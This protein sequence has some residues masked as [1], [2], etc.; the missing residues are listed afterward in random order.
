MTATP[1][2]FVYLA[3]LDEGAVASRVKIGYSANP[4]R[5][6]GELRTTAPLTT[7]HCTWSAHPAWEHA[8]RAAITAEGCVHVGGEVFDCLDIAG[9][10]RRG[11]AFFALMPGRPL[12][13]PGSVPAGF[14]SGAP[15]PREIELERR[16]LTAAIR[17]M[18]RQVGHTRD[19]CSTLLLEGVAVIGLDP[20]APD[21]RFGDEMPVTKGGFRAELLDAAVVASLTALSVHH[22][23]TV[24]HLMGYRLADTL[25]PTGPRSTWFRPLSDQEVK[26]FYQPAQADRD[27]FID[28]A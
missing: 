14:Y 9:L 10:G 17:A 1:P 11:D 12:R 22:V 23:Q 3:V 7:L 20:E 6:L 4:Q 24:M 5:R 25:H 26:S 8:A 19:L 18:E 21:D 2:G 15:G 27:P 28:M 16:A 13:Q